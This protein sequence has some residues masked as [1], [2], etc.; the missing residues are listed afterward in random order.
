[1]MDKGFWRIHR[2]ESNDDLVNGFPASAISVSR[3]SS[4]EQTVSLNDFSFFARAT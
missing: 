1:M 2:D 4:S 3:C